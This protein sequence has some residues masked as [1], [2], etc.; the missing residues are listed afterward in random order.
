MVWCGGFPAKS[1]GGCR[2]SSRVTGSGLRDH[3]LE[4]Q[5]L[6]NQLDAADELANAAEYLLRCRNGEGRWEKLQEALEAY[7]GLRGD[8]GG[9]G[10]G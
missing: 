5:V 8:D 9:Q 3:L 4:E 7:D 2:V 1:A 10:E 6:E